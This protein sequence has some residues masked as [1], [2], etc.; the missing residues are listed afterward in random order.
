MNSNLQH[1]YDVT[2][3]PQKRI[4]GL[5]SGTSLDGLDLALCRFTGYGLDTHVVVEHFETIPYPDDV[6]TK[7]RSVFSLS[8]IDLEQLCIYNSWLGNYWGDLILKTLKSWKVDSKNVDCIAS[9]GQTVYHAPLAKHGKL[10]LP[11]STLQIGDGDHIAMSTGILTISDFRQKHT[12]AGGQGAPLAIYEDYL[13]FRNDDEDRFML[14]IGGI[15]N[16]T[17]L[18]AKGNINQVICTDTGPGNTLIN[19]AVKTYFEGK[20]YDEN[21]WIAASG[22]VHAELLKR[23]MEH[24]FFKMNLPVT[25]GPEMFSFELIQKTLQ[26]YHWEEIS[27]ADLVATLTCFTAESIAH[28]IRKI[29]MDD[30]LK[31]VYVS[32]GVVHN[33]TLMNWL[34][35]LLPDFR[36]KNFDVLGMNPDAKEAVLFAL[37]ANE[38]LNG[39]GLPVL[40]RNG[41]IT[42]VNFG[43]ISF[44]N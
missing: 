17:Y 7:L 19:N 22:M 14:N 44:S 37:L 36:V 24:P 12:A 13:L 42:D 41:E 9:P 1:L 39:T 20:I 18:P 32:G 16:V 15:A 2:H 10:Q 4:L 6:K 21:G 30:S 43:K 27:P 28:F 11:D 3:K 25:T 40:K 33:V 29:G 5:M 23:L 8:M 26:K 35:E 31:T 34:T 38:T